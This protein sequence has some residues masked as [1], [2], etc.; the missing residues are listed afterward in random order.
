MSH[1]QS[2]LPEFDVFSSPGPVREPPGGQMLGGT[3]VRAASFL[4]N[5]GFSAM[6]GLGQS[7]EAPASPC[8]PGGKLDPVTGQCVG[9]GAPEKISTL[10][11]F[12]IIGVVGAL[13][14]Q[15]GKAMTPSGSKETTWGLVGIPL[16]IFG[17]PLGLGA[18]AL[19]AN[20]GRH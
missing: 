19:Y 7:T 5:P 8:P 16:T 1:Y 3:G 9:F 4:M 13:G 10:A 18:M 12:A 17:G 20:Y 15:V 6:R 2:I 14:Y 11:A